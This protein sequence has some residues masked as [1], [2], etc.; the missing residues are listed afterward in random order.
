MKLIPGKAIANSILEKIKHEVS[1]LDV[2]P[3]L[4]LIQASNDEATNIYVTSKIKDA[5]KVGI[6]VDRFHFD[7]FKYSEAR[8]LINRLNNEKYVNGVIIQLPI[9]VESG[10]NWL[11]YLSLVS[12][13]KDV[14]GLTYAS[15]G[16]LWQGTISNVF[17]PATV[18]GIIKCL[19]YVAIYEDGEY[20]SNEIDPN[21]INKKLDTYLKSKNIVIVNDSVVV[22]KPI[23]AILS[24]KSA[25]VTICHKHTTN[26]S[27]HIKNAD[28][29]VSATGVPRLINSD[30][31]KEGCVA[32]DVG[33]ARE[34]GK[35]VG[36][37]DFDS[38]KNRNIW[39]TPVP[40]GVGPLTRIMLLNNVVKAYNQQNR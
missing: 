32:I 40:G 14:D 10:A 37:F 16:K 35:V 39:A 12:E 7:E 22:G 18:E 6:E 9:V 36:D 17:W 33:I 31:L 25:T 11:D 29:I 28:I 21:V 5:L 13:E 1:I 15:Q 23:A 8:E 20:S 4:A 2:K 26:L 24:S 3:R 27:Q 34:N 30:S 19:E 38:L